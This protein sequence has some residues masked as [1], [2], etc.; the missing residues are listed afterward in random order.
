MQLFR[1]TQLVDQSVVRLVLI[2]DLRTLLDR[3]HIG[4]DF[5]ARRLVRFRA[6]VG[7]FVIVQHG[8]TGLRLDFLYIVADAVID[9]R[10]DGRVARTE[11]EDLVAVPDHFGLAVFIGGSIC[12]GRRNDITVFIFQGDRIRLFDGDHHVVS[13]V[14][15]LYSVCLVEEGGVAILLLYRMAGLCLRHIFGHPELIPGQGSQVELH[16]QIGRA[17]SPLHVNHLEIVGGVISE[18]IAPEVKVDQAVIPRCS[19][20]EDAGVFEAVLDR[21]RRDSVPAHI[22]GILDDHITGR[23]IDVASEGVVNTTDVQNQNSVDVDPQIV[24]TV[25]VVADRVPVAVDAVLILLELGIHDHAEE[26]V[27]VGRSFQA[28]EV[29]SLTGICRIESSVIVGPDLVGPGIGQDGI[30]EGHEV[31]PF[32]VVCIPVSVES[33]RGRGN[34]HLLIYGEIPRFRMEAGVV[35]KGAVA[36]IS[37]RVIYALQEKVIGVPGLDRVIL[38]SVGLENIAQGP[39]PL[40]GGRP[41]SVGPVRLLCK[42]IRYQARI[43]PACLPAALSH[44]RTH[45]GQTLAVPPIIRPGP[46]LIEVVHGDGDAFILAVH[47]IDFGQLLLDDGVAD[48]E[49]EFLRIHQVL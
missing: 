33:G 43:I 49:I 2:D 10:E 20:R 12:I 25:E 41:V 30:V 40:G 32:L 48:S 34:A 4:Q 36:E 13:V 15:F 38:S 14:I 7:H 1:D 26:I 46:V 28:V 22:D 19:V 8:C 11:L 42:R 29:L 31:A 17:G 27:P 47:G 3:P 37:G 24:V 9:H 6:A 5:L 16:L 23:K 44:D 35:L 18:G 45:V 39:V 21:G